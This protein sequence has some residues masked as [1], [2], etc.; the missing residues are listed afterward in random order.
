MQLGCLSGHAG[1]RRLP[2][3]SL[4]RH[5]Q[6]PL[7]TPNPA[8]VRQRCIARSVGHRSNS[9]NWAQFALNSLR[10]NRSNSADQ[11]RH[12]AANNH[13][14]A[15]VDSPGPA[16]LVGASAKQLLQTAVH[17]LDLFEPR[18]SS[19]IESIHTLDD[20]LDSFEESHTG[21]LATA[22]IVKAN[23]EVSWQSG[24]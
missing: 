20:G 7:C 4:Q 24:M 1:Q 13:N 14:V 6:H 11:Q 18:E 9:S 12:K 15:S 3:S 21:A 16:A 2:G 8:A 5:V 23:Y 22:H 19:S 17:S 10:V